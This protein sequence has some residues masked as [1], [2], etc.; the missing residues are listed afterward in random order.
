M[1]APRPEEAQRAIELFRAGRDEEVIALARGFT[2]RHPAHALGWMLWAAALKRRLNMSTVG[3]FGG[4]GMGQTCGVAD[5]SQWMRQFG[6]DIDS[7]DTGH[8]RIAPAC[9]PLRFRT[10]RGS[11]TSPSR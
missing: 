8:R 9:T 1:T 2:Q 6:I 10:S 3:V 4:R 5:P 7:R 11:A